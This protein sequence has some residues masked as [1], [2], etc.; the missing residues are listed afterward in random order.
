MLTILASALPAEGN[1]QGFR[2]PEQ[3]MTF[4]IGPGRTSTDSDGFVWVDKQFPGG[5]VV[6]ARDKSVTL[7]LSAGAMVSQ[8]L[9]VLGGLDLLGGNSAVGVAPIHLFGGLR[10]IAGRAWVEGGLGPTY[11]R[12][13][14]RE[15]EES[16]ESGKWGVG[17][18]GVVGFDLIQ[19]RDASFLSQGHFT[20]SVQA[21]ASTH[22][23]G[24]MRTNT[25]ALLLGFAIGW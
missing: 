2:P 1:A 25:L 18:L 5:I 22:A 12:V 7:E 15:G 16:V 6:P 13:I 14:A 23:A 9:A 8:R 21:R 17:L 11:M 3:F 4:S 10:W 19:R 20:A 24:G